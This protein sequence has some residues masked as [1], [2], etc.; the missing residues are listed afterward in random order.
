M[1]SQ[2]Q[3]MDGMLG[4][5]A[6]LDAFTKSECEI[7][8]KAISG[9]PTDEALLVGRNKD[10]NLRKSELVWIDDVVSTQWV[11]ERLIDLVRKANRDQFE[12]DLTEFAESPQVAIYKSSES[13]HF[14]WHSDI[15]SGTAAGRRKLTLV[16]QLSDAEAY[17]G[18][19]LEIMPGAQILTASRAQGCASIFPSFTL[20][21]V[22]PVTNGTRYSMTVWAHGPAFR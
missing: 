20:H 15:G 2:F 19:E 12:F 8:I 3:R 14:S 22:T 16:L 7:I 5:N 6:M 21:Q 9:L 1:F 4:L 10:Q 13:G 18:G 17:E 11:M